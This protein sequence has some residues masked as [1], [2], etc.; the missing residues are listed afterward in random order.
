MCDWVPGAEKSPGRID[1]FVYALSML[2]LNVYCESDFDI[3]MCVA[4]TRK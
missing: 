3:P 1:A 4:P 2:N